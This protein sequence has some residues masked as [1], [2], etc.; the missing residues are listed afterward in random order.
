M[1]YNLIY[2]K[3]L[4]IHDVITVTSGKNV[5]GSKRYACKPWSRKKVLKEIFGVSSDENEAF[6]RAFAEVTNGKGSERN[7]ITTLHSSSLLGLLTFFN[8]SENKPVWICGIKYNKAFFEVESKVLD[9]NASIDVMLVSEDEKALLFLELKFT[10]FLSPRSHLWLS[11]KY[12]D[13]YRSLSDEL[14]KSGIAVG[15]VEQRI[16]RSRKDGTKYT[17]DEFMISDVDRCKRYFGGIKQMISHLY[18]LTRCPASGTKNVYESYVAGK[19]PHI[20]L[21]TMLYEP[22]IYELRDLFDSYRTL[23][24][25]VFSKENDIPSK[26]K[27]FINADRKYN[28]EILD[29]PLTYQK[30]VKN[31]NG[32]LPYLDRVKSIYRFK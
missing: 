5:D 10:E 30:D 11:D 9:S 31:E 22:F 3:I 4:D 32:E 23:Y 8:V 28:V 6:D 12:F 21:A 19:Q 16:H 20:I 14:S 18:G 7:R 29:T 25:S 2:D 13:L 24:C 15:E 27:S 26:I 1:N 17:T